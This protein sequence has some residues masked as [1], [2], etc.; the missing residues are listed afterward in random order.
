MT[1][2]DHAEVRAKLTAD[3]SANPAQVEF[4]LD[5]YGFTTDLR[6]AGL[7]A[8][9]RIAADPDKYEVFATTLSIILAHAKARMKS[10]KLSRKKQLDD[11]QRFAKDREERTCT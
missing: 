7:A 11:I 9:Q 10:D 1:K 4:P 3:V 8:A 5:V 6:K 2:T